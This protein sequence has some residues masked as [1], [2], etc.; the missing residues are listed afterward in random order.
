MSYYIIT[1]LQ[2]INIC[3]KINVTQHVLELIRSI[4]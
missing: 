1:F 4:L 2:V 3:T